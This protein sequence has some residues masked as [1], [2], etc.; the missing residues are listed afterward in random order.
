MGKLESG[1]SWVLGVRKALTEDDMLQ[2]EGKTNCETSSSNYPLH[3]LLLS[4]EGKKRKKKVKGDNLVV[5]QNRENSN[6]IKK[7]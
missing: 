2:Q 3:Y 5:C 7:P 4:M 1:F 6:R